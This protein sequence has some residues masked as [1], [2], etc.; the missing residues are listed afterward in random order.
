MEPT[1]S[2]GDVVV[3]RKADG[4]WQRWTRA[5]PSTTV[6]TQKGS[7][8]D[9]LPSGYDWAVER[10]Q[11]L[12]YEK[13]HCRSNPRTGW[14][15]IPPVPVNGNIVVYQDPEMYPSKLNIKRV[16]GLSGQIVSS[17]CCCYC[18]CFYLYQILFTFLR[19][20]ATL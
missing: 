14:L 11:V 19:M 20:V 17:C 13:E 12:E 15:R 9:P 10:S 16:N 3:V 18:C 5:W 7:T 2:D 4:L 6:R 8:V 1:L